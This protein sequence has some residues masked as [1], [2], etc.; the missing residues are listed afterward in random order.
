ML[1]A[2][3]VYTYQLIAKQYINSLAMEMCGQSEATL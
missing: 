1:L 2:C 3:M